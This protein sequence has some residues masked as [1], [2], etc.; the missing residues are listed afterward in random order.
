MATTYILAGGADSSYP[1][2]MVQLSRVVHSMV[3]RPKIL[4]CGFASDD[5]RAKEKFPKYKEAFEQKFGNFA[6]FVMAEK[7]AFAEQ[8]KAADVVYFH[9]GSTNSLVDAM[10]AYPGIEKEYAGKI[11]IGSSAGANYLSSCGF[12]PS[13]ND[14]GQSGGIVDVAVVV[15]YG[16]PGFNGMSFEPGYWGRAADAVRQASGGKEVLL[17]PEGTFAVIRK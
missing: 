1:E 14:I 17:L 12:S 15:H 13:I 8:V 5:T 4:S 10:R 2:Y 7:D 3:A 6:E 9:G 11:I 16:S